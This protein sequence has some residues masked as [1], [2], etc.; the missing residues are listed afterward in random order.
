MKITARNILSQIG[1]MPKIIWKGFESIITLKHITSFV[2]RTISKGENV[3]TNPYDTANILNNYFSSVSDTL[4]I[5][6]N[7]FQITLIT[8]AIILYSFSLLTV[9]K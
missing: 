3:I 1:I 7:T 8:S 9:R 2:P 5:I 6:I 4:S